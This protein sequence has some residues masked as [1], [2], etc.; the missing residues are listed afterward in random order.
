[1]KQASNNDMKIRDQRLRWFGLLVL[2]GSIIVCPALFAS[3]APGGDH[4]KVKDDAANIV[5]GAAVSNGA[6]GERLFLQAKD[7][8]TKGDYLNSAK[9]CWDYLA[10]NSVNAEK[11]ESAQF[12]L[13]SSLEKLGF[14]HAAVEYYFQVANNRRMPELLPRALQAIEAITLRSYFDE[15]LIIRD[16][17]SDADFSDVPADLADFAHYW[18][19]IQNLSQGLETWASEQFNKISHRGYYFFSALYAASIRLLMPGEQPSKLEAVTSFS[20]LFGAMDLSAALE[21]MRRRGEGDIPLA[22]SIKALINEDNEIQIQYEK[23]P[24][25]WELELAMFG[26]ARISAESG[27]ILARAKGSDDDILGMSLAYT[28]K[29]GDIPLYVRAIKYE[30]RAPAIKAVASRFEAV[31]KLRGKAMHSNARLLFEQKSFNEAYNILTKIPKGTEDE[32]EILLER[33][34]AKYK[35]GDPHRAMGLVYAMDAPAYRKLFAPEKFL[36]RGLI[37]RRFCHFSEAKQAVREY[38]NLFS[39]ALLKVKEGKSLAKIAEIR[40]AGRRRGLAKKLYQFQQLL[41]QENTWLAAKESVWQENGLLENLRNLYQ[42]KLKQITDELNRALENSTK[43][44][45]EEM[46]NAEEQMN[47]FEYE[48]GQSIF[49]RVSENKEGQLRKY[50]P[51]VPLSSERVYYPFN[52]EYWSDE[53]RNYRFNLEDRCVE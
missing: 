14:S 1:M 38:K 40:D 22:L 31:R 16:L 52:G 11:Y 27:A 12:Y 50:S 36:L 13:A 4:A 46:L 3:A 34:W 29:I 33:A 17:L 7:E 6:P 26:L 20:S 5:A 32:S 25:G 10:K 44:V 41:T 19:G 24:A 2:I 49:Q 45:G 53:L 21:A 8:F 39:E 30:D 35:A 48:I 43:E 15:E 23:L 51:K 28:V 42:R 47:L 9:H 37:F 18:Q